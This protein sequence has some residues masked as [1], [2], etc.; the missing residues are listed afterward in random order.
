MSRYIKLSGREAPLL[1]SFGDGGHQHAESIDLTASDN[2]NASA[3]SKPTARPDEDPPTG[4]FQQPS[5]HARCGRDRGRSGHSGRRPTPSPRS[6][7]RRC[8]APVALDVRDGS[9][10]AI[11]RYGPELS[12]PPKTK[13]REGLAA[14]AA[15]RLAL[16]G[17][18]HVSSPNRESSIVAP[19]LEGV[20]IGDPND[21]AEEHGRQHGRALEHRVR[22]HT[23]RKAILLPTR[24]GLI[25]AAL[26]YRT[27]TWFSN[28]AS[29]FASVSSSPS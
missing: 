5:L 26:V 7:E 27:P 16:L 2:R 23:A 20:A 1:D 12:G 21:E 9:A 29:A 13:R 19:S 6:P 25:R 14:P 15:E 17:S 4:R 28:F 3:L 22:G 18:V 10:V 11:H 24:L 8:V